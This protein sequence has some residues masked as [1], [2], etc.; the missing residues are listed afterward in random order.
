MLVENTK[1]TQPSTIVSKT[2]TE[3][4]RQQEE[5]FRDILLLLQNLF[6]REDKTVLMVID[7]LYD[8]GLVNFIN[9]KIS[10]RPINEL[11][12]SILKL[13]KPLFKIIA[14]RW[15]KKNAPLAIT[16]WL[17]DKVRF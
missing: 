16:K 7:C 14:L 6:E 5:R 2:L 13:P 11:F 4:K 8:L 10:S 17:Y 12:K 3:E 1:D 9:K 15:V